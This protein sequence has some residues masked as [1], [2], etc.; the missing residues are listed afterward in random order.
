MGMG[1]VVCLILMG[2]LLWIGAVPCYGADV[3][4]TWDLEGYRLDDIQEF[5]NGA[6]KEEALNLSFTELM[7]D[8]L[9]GDFSGAVER[10]GNALEQ[11]LFSELRDH[12]ALIGQIVVLGL[13]GAVF[14]NFSNIFSSSQI[15]ETA[16]FVTYLLMFTFLSAS[17]FSSVQIAA[18]V[19]QRILEFI[20]VLMPS[21]FMAVAFTGGSVTAVALYELAMLAVSGIQWL[22]LNLLIPMVRVYLLFVLASHIA[23]EDVLSKLTELIE[24]GVGWSLK[25]MTG[26]VLGFHVIQGMI[27]PYVDNMKN[28][29]VRKL[30]EVIPGIGQGAGVMTQMLLGSGVLIKN[31]MGVAGIVVLLLIALVPVVKLTLMM[32]LYQCVAAAL[33]PVCDRRSFPV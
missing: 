18:R 32:L 8:L 11:T 9:G 7:K 33:E 17:F 6:G 2:F 26:L 30:V 22:E 12:G 28:S 21:F 19:V 14:A 24:H 4:E 20:R 15:S 1:I 25:T 5:L 3:G 23:K 16:F 27:L 31:T 29:G 13:L 10:M